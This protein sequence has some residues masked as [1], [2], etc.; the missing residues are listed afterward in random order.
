[1]YRKAL[2][3]LPQTVQT[4]TRFREKLLTELQHTGSLKY[5]S[6]LGII[7][8]YLQLSTQKFFASIKAE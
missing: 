8:S 7:L 3:L 1:M 2:I 4:K 5:G 6:M